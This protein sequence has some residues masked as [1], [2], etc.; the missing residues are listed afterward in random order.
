MDP[1]EAR[2]SFLKTLQRLNATVQANDAA[3][4]F[5]L[6]NHDGLAED[7]YSCVLEE[8]ERGTINVRANVLTFVDALCEKILAMNGSNPHRYQYVSWIFRDMQTIVERA[9]PE[10][11]QGNIN[12]RTAKEILK[13]LRAKS[14]SLQMDTKPIDNALEWLQRRDSSADSQPAVGTGMPREQ[15]L[16]RMEDDR[17]RAKRQKESQWQVDYTVPDDEFNAMWTN[18]GPLDDIDYEQMREDNEIS[19]IA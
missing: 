10:G 2:L 11:N 16:Q 6:K 13:R 7:L 4:H 17:E 12:V 18:L 8:L 19:N 14:A 1:F 5:M 9:V 15:I 3:A